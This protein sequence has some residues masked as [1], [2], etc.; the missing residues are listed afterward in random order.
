MENE[1][2]NVVKKEANLPVTGM[3]EQ[4]ASQG[5]EN[6]AQDDLALPFLRI[7]GQLSATRGDSAVEGRTRYDL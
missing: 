5:L 6:M 2:G 1:T 4:D 7:L 3:F